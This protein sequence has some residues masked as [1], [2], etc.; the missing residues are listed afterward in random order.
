MGEWWIPP[1]VA[2][3]WIVDDEC[4]HPRAH[5]H[6]DTHVFDDG[7][8]SGSFDPCENLSRVAERAAQV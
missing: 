1:L 6:T 8:I 3:L 5:L 4:H 2:S 7:I